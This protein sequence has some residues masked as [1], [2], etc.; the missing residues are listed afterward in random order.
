MLSNTESLMAALKE[1]MHIISK[2]Q[3]QIGYDAF[4]EMDTLHRCIKETL[5]MH[6][7]APVLFR[8]AHETFR[9]QTKEGKEYD[10]PGGHNVVI[11]T[12]L[13]HKLPCIYKDPEAYDP[14]RFALG[15][16]EDKVGGKYSFTSFGGGR[17]F[18][19]GMSFAYLQIKVIWSHLLR[20]FESKIISP[21]PKTDWR[22][23]GGEPKGKLMISYKRRQLTC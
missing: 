12:A 8:K 7:P 3:N 2:Y 6:T 20:N 13:N 16:E 19:P 21:F 14:D 18:C 5:R 4:L 9:V 11:P 1:Q 22:N 10:I 17:H 23:L 15:R